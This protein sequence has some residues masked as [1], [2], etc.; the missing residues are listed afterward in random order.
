VEIPLKS[1]SLVQ[2]NALMREL[3]DTAKTACENDQGDKAYRIH[4]YLQTVEENFS[5]SIIQSM[6]GLV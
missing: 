3:I 2:D 4:E 1:Y 6:E 5:G